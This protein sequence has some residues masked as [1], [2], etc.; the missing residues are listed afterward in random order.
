MR[1]STG[2][3]PNSENGIS[4]GAVV[5]NDAA[6][7]LPSF[8][9]QSLIDE[10]VQE[11]IKSVILA[12][13]IPPH[14]DWDKVTKNQIHS[15]TAENYILLMRN[16]FLVHFAGRVVSSIETWEVQQHFDRLALKYSNSVIIKVHFLLHRMYRRAQV[17][18]G[19]DNPFNSDD[20]IIPVSTKKDRKVEPYSDAEMQNLI[21][22]VDD[23]PILKPIINLTASTGCR[24]QEI[25]N[26][27]WK[28]ID[29]NNGSIRI[30]RALTLHVDF[31]ESGFILHRQS[32]D[33][34]TKRQSSERTLFIDEYM[35][36]LLSA[37]REYAALYTKTGFKPGDYVFG[38]TRNDHYTYWGFRAVLRR[39]LDIKY[40]KTHG[41]TALHRIRHTVAT[42]AAE[43]GAS[44][45][46][47]MQLLGDNQERSVLRYTGRS[48]LIAKKNR[49]RI[50]K[51]MFV[52]R[53][54]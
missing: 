7:I 19:L 13:V 29:L 24:L 15:R 20:F 2:I 49:D 17:K 50:S 46:E 37:W 28:H 32:V 48:A 22:G 35:L 4:N 14:L 23:H 26:L 52:F 25:L 45:I 51:S 36:N 1:K 53:Q 6:R 54:P 38:N 11:H 39:H 30:E 42:K 31:D 5:Q 12:N 21:S 16:H 18:W 34:R 33:G 43:E 8:T 27:R 40:G 41:L 47:L 44:T 9:K 3:Y 10:I